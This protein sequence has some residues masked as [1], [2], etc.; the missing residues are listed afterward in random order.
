MNAARQSLALAHRALLRTVKAPEQL[1]DVIIQPVI[2]LVVMAYLFGGAVAGSVGDYLQFLVPGILGMSILMAAIPI[3]V[4][5][6]SDMEKGIFD[7]F[8]SLPIARPAPLIGAVLGDVVRYVIVTVVTLVTGLV[9]G[10]RIGTDVPSAL[11]ACALAVLFAMSLSWVSV[12]A[13]MLARSPGAVQG[14]LFPV[15]I[16]L[17]YASNVFVPVGTLP[18]WLQAIV[19]VNPL[20]HLVDAMRA[21]LI[22]GD[23]G[24]SVW[25]L[26]AWCVGLVM[27]FGS[28]ASRAYRRR[29]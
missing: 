1:L 5:L 8:R 6:N 9:M 13:G 4:N 11:L 23:M 27:V 17:M 18:G 2:M 20:T 25:W 19:G 28:L 22:G 10:F 26:L 16:P 14:I 21:L 29:V 24:S 12:L 15:L 7:R 3:G